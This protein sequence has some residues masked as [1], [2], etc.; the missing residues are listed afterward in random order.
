MSVLPGVRILLTG[1]G[2]P[3]AVSVFQ[4]LRQEPVTWFMGDMDGAAVGLYLVPAGRRILLRPGDDPSF[5]DDVLRICAENHIEMVLPTVD[6][7]LLPLARRRADFEAAGVTLLTSD[8]SA[9]SAAVDKLTTVESAARVTFVPHTAAVDEWFEPTGWGPFVL[10]PRH[11]SGGTGVHICRADGA[12]PD[13]VP[14]DGS[15][16]AQTFLPGT[17]Y[18]VDVLI[19]RDGAAIAVPRERLKVDSGIAVCARTVHDEELQRSAIAVYQR[20]GLRGIANIQFRRDRNGRPALLEVNPRPPGTLTL[21]VAAGA[22]LPLLWLADELGVSVETPSDFRDL[23]VVR[24]WQDIVVES[25]QL[26]VDA[27]TEVA[28]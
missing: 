13:E 20:L 24:H 21:T 5:A 15:Y 22:N 17:E 25:D 27:N 7:E 9:L 23:A 8:A 11:G 14:R 6:V 18:S 16:I 3:A 1:A 10:K 2:G 26:L 19:R 4:S 28:A 12:V